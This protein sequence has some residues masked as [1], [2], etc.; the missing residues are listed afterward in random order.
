M[1]R[2][3]LVLVTPPTS[4]PVTLAEAKAWCRLDGTDEDALLT[5]LIISARQA[6]EEYLRR[7]LIS[8]SWKLTLDL[9]QNHGQ[10][11]DGVR[12]GAIT[13]LYGA[14]PRTIP[15]PKGPVRSITSVTT[16]DLNNASAVYDAAN[17]RVDASGDRLILNS[18]AFWPSSIRPQAGC[19]IL[20][21]AGYGAGADVPKPIKTGMLT[22]IA[23]LYEQRGQCDDPMPV[24]VE[25]QYSRYRIMGDRL[26]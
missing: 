21:I 2:Q 20:Y 26:G 24:A 5:E 8:Q 4:E 1:L 9:G 17:Y 10:W 16:Y 6:A 23:S 14:L 7:S 22:H 19:E 12:D 13:A 25:Q 15:L 3:S 11:W 18:G